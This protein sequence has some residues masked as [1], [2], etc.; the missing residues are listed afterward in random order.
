M[1]YYSSHTLKPYASLTG[2]YSVGDAARL[3]RLRFL[4]T[5][6]FPVGFST[7]L[8]IVLTSSNEQC[9]EK[10]VDLIWF[11]LFYSKYYSS[12]CSLLVNTTK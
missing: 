3:T 9:Q 4:D 2:L 11:F 8:V 5:N 7:S 1:R 12:V 10:T 6:V